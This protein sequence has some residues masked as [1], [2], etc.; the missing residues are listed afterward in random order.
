VG[1]SKSSKLLTSYEVVEAANQ[2]DEENPC[3]KILLSV[4]HTTG[5][6]ESGKL[7]ELARQAAGPLFPLNEGWNLR[8]ANETPDGVELVLGK[9]AEAPEYSFEERELWGEAAL[10]WSTEVLNAFVS[11]K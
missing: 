3:K 4:H 6:P 1:G 8:Q 11:E 2:M 10:A 7:A 5:G 9:L